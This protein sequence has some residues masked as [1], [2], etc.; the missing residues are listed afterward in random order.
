[1]TWPSSIALSQWLI[2]H[3]HEVI[4]QKTI[5][6]LGAGTGL[7][8]MVVAKLIAHHTEI[9]KD[10]YHLQGGRVIL[11]DYNPLVLD[12]I[13]RSIQLNNLQDYAE[14]SCLDFY[15]QNGRNHTG[16]WLESLPTLSRGHDETS[17]IPHLR[18][19]EAVDII[20]AADVICQ[21]SDSI[22]LSKTIYDALRPGGKAFVTSA[23][24]AH[25]FGVDYFPSECFKRGLIV[26]ESTLIPHKNMNGIYLSTTSGFVEGMEM[27]LY[28]IVKH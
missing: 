12:N 25:R 8:G 2:D 16:G 4:N 10:T 17:A 9:H 26:T 5:L 18:P 1:V 28:E 11:S 6:E 24:S 15:H 22:S 23:A 13:Q 3:C 27:K 20:L 19:R 7:V 21:P 14:I